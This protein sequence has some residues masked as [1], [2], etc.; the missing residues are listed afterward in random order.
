MLKIICFFL[1][2]LWFALD[3]VDIYLTRD[4]IRA[5]KTIEKVKTMRWWMANDFRAIM[6]WILELPAFLIPTYFFPLMALPF[7]LYE[8]IFVKIKVCIKNY[9]LNISALK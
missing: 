7:W 6:L 3:A 4:G 2:G 9:K 5:G 8:V 1:A